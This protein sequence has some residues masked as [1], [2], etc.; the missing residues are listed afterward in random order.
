M[1]GASESLGLV[2]GQ[3]PPVCPHLIEAVAEPLAERRDGMVELD[4][5]IGVG[6]RV[7]LL[8]DPLR[9]GDEPAGSLVVAVVEREHPGVEV[10]VRAE[11][12]VVVGEDPRARRPEPV[13]FR[14]S[15]SAPWLVGSKRAHSSR[16]ANRERTETD[17]PASI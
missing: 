5:V 10:R 6:D 12:G 4:V 8:E 15:G 2:I 3:R 17:W 7:R 1:L 13:G 14:N 16:Q 9:T 11:V